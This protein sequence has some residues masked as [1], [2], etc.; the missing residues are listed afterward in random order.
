MLAD[1]TGKTALV[2]GAGMGLGRAI[3]LALAEQGAD[4]ALTD[5]KEEWPAQVA[6]E[7]S[8]S[9]AMV[10]EMDVTC[11]DSVDGA[12][13]E[14]LAEWGHLDILVNNA[15]VSS[16]AAA[17]R[18]AE[19]WE[20]DWDV[21]FDINVKGVVRCCRA[22]IPHMKERRYGKI[23]NIASISGHSAH[24]R[25]G[26]AYGVSKASVL[27]YTK[28]LTKEL[29]PYNINVNAV[30]PGAVWTD[31]HLRGW[32]R[33][34]Q[35]D[36]ALADKDPYQAFLEFYEQQFPLRRPQR[37]EDIGKAVA[38]LA[39]DDACNITGQC[40]HVDGGMIIDD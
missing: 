39:S 15:G 16:A 29:G 30:C 31:F 12:F 36:P 2:T 23:V 37:P 18:E 10:V 13:Q 8:R 26:G 22:V 21:T 40:L 27:R 34:V 25:S 33:R 7:V 5:L 17:G 14:V 38:F 35:S 9:R 1:L 20:T 28:G 4:V 24:P 32:S 6:K 11:Q 3:A 19:K